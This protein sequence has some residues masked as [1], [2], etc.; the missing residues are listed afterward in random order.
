MRLLEPFF[1]W[2]KRELYQQR[3]NLIEM[4]EEHFDEDNPHNISLYGGRYGDWGYNYYDFQYEPRRLEELLQDTEDAIL[5]LQGHEVPCRE[6]Y[7]V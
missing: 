2:E 7:Y 5:R 4:L 1:I 6:L 3:G